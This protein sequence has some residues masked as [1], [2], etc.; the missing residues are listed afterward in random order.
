[1]IWTQREKIRKSIVLILHQEWGIIS[2]EFIEA[3][4][5]IPKYTNYF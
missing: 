3:R 2:G 1:M 4:H 5:T